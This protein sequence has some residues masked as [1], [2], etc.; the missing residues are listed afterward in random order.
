MT[1]A[2]QDHSEPEVELELYE[3]TT[4]LREVT[5]E[6]HEVFEELMAS[7][8][9]EKQALKIVGHIMYDVMASRFMDDEDDEEDDDFEGDP[10]E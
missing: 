10:S 7:G 6:T 2:P 4:P 9:S 5:I 8:F 3:H 1:D